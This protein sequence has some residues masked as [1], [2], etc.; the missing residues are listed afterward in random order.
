M[1]PKRIAAA[2]V[3]LPLLMTSTAMAEI[4]TKEDLH[5]SYDPSYVNLA[6]SNGHFPVVLVDSPIA[7]DTLLKTLSL[8]GYFPQVPL[9]ETAADR[10]TGERLVLAFHAPQ[11][12]DGAD[13]CRNPAALAGNPAKGELRVQAAFCIGNEVLSEA[14]MT[15]QK[16]IRVDDPAFKTAMTHL[17]SVVLSTQNPNDDGANDGNLMMTK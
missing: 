12:S 8:P 15:T 6:A 9:T 16:P 14:V 5:P 3:L 17:M 1:L 7:G 10:A 4:I 11:S 2:V 13:A